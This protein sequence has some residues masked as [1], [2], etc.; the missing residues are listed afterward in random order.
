MV[1]KFVGGG[2]WIGS[3]MACKG[4][5]EKPYCRWLLLKIASR[6][7]LCFMRIARGWGDVKLLYTEKT[8][9]VAAVRM[10]L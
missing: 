8:K 2:R 3:I 4:G 6:I 9:W 5:D 1:G 7:S 10:S